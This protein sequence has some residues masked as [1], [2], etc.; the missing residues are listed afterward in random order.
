MNFF[1]LWVNTKENILIRKKK[2]GG[3][4]KAY[5]KYTASAKR[6][7]RAKQEGQQKPHPPSP[8]AQ[9]IKKVD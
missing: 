1:F 9:P 4:P 3:Q 6:L 8:R 7:K 5:R 2:P